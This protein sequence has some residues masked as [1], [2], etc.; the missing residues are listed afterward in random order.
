MGVAK[1]PLYNSER[2]RVVA[3][4]ASFC[5]APRGAVIEIILK[6]PIYVDSGDY[7]AITLPHGRVK[8]GPS[9][10]DAVL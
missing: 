7:D 2:H 4:A 10:T 9:D 5:K 3:Q 8:G 6:P 1:A